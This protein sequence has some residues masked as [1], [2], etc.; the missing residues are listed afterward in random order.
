MCKWSISNHPTLQQALY[1]TI[2]V[3][4]GKQRITIGQHYS[5]KKLKIVSEF[6]SENEYNLLVTTDT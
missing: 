6:V 4:Y 3:V 5:Q 2:K 1:S